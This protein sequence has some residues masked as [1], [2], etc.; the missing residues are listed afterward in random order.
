VKSFFKKNYLPNNA[1]IV[2]AGNVKTEEIRSLSEKWFGD[3][4]AGNINGKMLPQ[5]PEQKEPRFLQ[6]ESKVPAHSITK[7]YHMPARFDPGYYP[8]DLLSDILG[9]GK[10]SR[11]HNQLVQVNQIFSSINAYLT[12]SLDPGLLVIEGKLNPGVEME[13][14]EDEISKI[15]NKLKSELIEDSELE[16]VVS[17]AESTMVFSEV[18]ILN[19]AMNL[20]FF[21]LTGDAGNINLE[22]KK[23]KKVSAADIRESANYILKDENCSTLH[24]FSKPN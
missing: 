21:D 24:Y 13:S 20:A 6:I 19:R 4:P 18:E 2:V 16:K 12:G 23:I 5:E 15:I 14:A 22:L 8:A 3:I 17:Q 11:L 9:R 1:T 10:S 7:A